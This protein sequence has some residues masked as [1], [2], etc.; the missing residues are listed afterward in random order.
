MNLIK[1]LDKNNGLDLILHAPG[2]DV[3]ATESIIDYLY[4]V[5]NGDIRVIIPQIAMSGGTMIACSSKEI[6]M[7]KQ[8]SLGPIDPQFNGIP[9]EIVIKEFYRAKNEISE[10]PE[11]IPFWQTNI[12][13]YPP[14]FIILCENARKWSDEILDKSLRYA[15]FDGSDEE[16]INKIRLELGS[17]ENT[18]SHGRHLSAKDCQELGLKISY[19]EDDDEF[20]DTVLSIHHACMN[21]F[22]IN[23]DCCKIVANNDSKFFIQ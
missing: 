12:S 10:K 17:H 19:L 9:A 11:T 7:G 13:K 1:G 3:G 22:S 21:F 8:S 15:M 5:F 14:A 2:G 4:E 6:I 18:K 23:K 20:Q 16:K